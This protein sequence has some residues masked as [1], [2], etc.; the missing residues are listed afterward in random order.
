MK[1]QNSQYNQFEYQ[2]IYGKELTIESERF[3]AEIVFKNQ[4]MYTTIQR[5]ETLFTRDKK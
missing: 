4:G 2:P 3:L 1:I 5:I